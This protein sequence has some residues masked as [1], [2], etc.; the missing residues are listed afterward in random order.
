MLDCHPEPPTERGVI[1]A[2]QDARG[3]DLEKLTPTMV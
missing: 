2:L 1:T 3:S